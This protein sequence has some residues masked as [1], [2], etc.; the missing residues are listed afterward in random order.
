MHIG[1][2]G[3]DG[4]YVVIDAGDGQVSPQMTIN[5]SAQRK[6]LPVR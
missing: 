4:V 5:T 1:G 3:K 6:S 2:D